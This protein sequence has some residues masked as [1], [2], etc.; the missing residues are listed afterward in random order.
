MPDSLLTTPDIVAVVTWA[1][2]LIQAK[3]NNKAEI[4]VFR[5]EFFIVEI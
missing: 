2:V 1:F 5:I 4:I 3:E